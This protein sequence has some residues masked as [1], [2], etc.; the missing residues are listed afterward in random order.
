MLN[1]TQTAHYKKN[2]PSTADL[3]HN[4]PLAAYCV[5][6][7]P[8][9]KMILIAPPR[10]GAFPRMDTIPFI[11]MTIVCLP[12]AFPSS[13]QNP[14][15]IMRERIISHLW[16]AHNA[17][18]VLFSA[19]HWAR[20]L[21]FYGLNASMFSYAKSVFNWAASNSVWP[22]LEVKHSLISPPKWSLFYSRTV[23]RP[24]KPLKGVVT[25]VNLGSPLFSV[26][27]DTIQC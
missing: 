7:H 8:E 23:F 26:F 10:A 16:E 11:W 20:W 24:R 13:L 18:K 27:Y 21:H 5:G 4:F 22:L 9:E 2:N 12:A 14:A 6:N 3:F 1:I 15:I 25:C 19:G 17:Q